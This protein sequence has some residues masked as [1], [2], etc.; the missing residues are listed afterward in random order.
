MSEPTG[1]LSLPD[2]IHYDVPSEVYHKR[3]LGVVSNSAL[4]QVARTPRHY[5]AWVDG[6]DKESPAMDFGRAFH[7]A[8]LEPAR[9]AQSFP[10]LP[11]FKGTGSVAAKARWVED[12]GPDAQPIKPEAAERIA[13]M[14]A[15]IREHP[16]AREAVLHGAAEATVL[17]TDEAT[18]LR[19][20]A[21]A[22]YYRQDKGVLL[23]IKTCRDASP[24]GFARALSEYRY[25]V[26]CALYVE[27]FQALGDPIHHY[28]ML[29]IESE[30][31]HCCAT[32]TLTADTEGRGFELL[33]RDREVLATCLRADYWPA[34]S[35]KTLAL[36]LP[37]W[38]L[39]D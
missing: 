31:P 8:L 33:D 19:H 17:W 6:L 10:I 11:E 2:G 16:V 26:A 3:V 18:G 28:L 14:V 29:A 36:S 37:R 22:D 5:R 35:D 32:Y 25:H 21:R 27:G 38:A 15:S 24:G 4:S 39:H 1:L 13:A 23:E 7:C 20:K 34:Y 30:P 12:Q 9:F